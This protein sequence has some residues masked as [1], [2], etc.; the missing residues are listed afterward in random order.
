MCGRR[1]IGPTEQRLAQH[2][3]EQLAPITVLSCSCPVAVVYSY[4]GGRPWAQRGRRKSHSS[5]HSVCPGRV[6]TSYHTS[7]VSKGEGDADLHPPRWHKKKVSCEVWRSC[8]R[9]C[10]IMPPIG[11]YFIARTAGCGAAS[12]VVNAGTQSCPNRIQ[13]PRLPIWSQ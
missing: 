9:Y 13:A 1:S 5:V 10:I 7:P 6:V 8:E 2:V 11:A 4:I 12:K 3:H